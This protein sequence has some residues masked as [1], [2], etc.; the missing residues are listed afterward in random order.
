MTIWPPFSSD[1]F[2]YERIMSI[3]VHDVL[4][5]AKKLAGRLKK[6]DASTDGLLAKAQGLEK[7]VESMKEVCMHSFSCRYN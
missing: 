5:D 3:S 7:T 1:S 4:N 6:F 2:E